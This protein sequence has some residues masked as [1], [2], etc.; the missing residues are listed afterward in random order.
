MEDKKKLTLW[1]EASHRGLSCW[2][3]PALLPGCSSALPATRNADLHPRCAEY[4][5]CPHQ[6][7]SISLHQ[8]KL[9]VASPSVPDL[10]LPLVVEMVVWVVQQHL[11]NQIPNCL[12][13]GI[14][15]PP[16]NRK[17]PWHSLGPGCTSRTAPSKPPWWPTLFIQ[18]IPHDY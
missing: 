5:L 13:Q 2:T 4:K 17:L 10:C 18:N 3:V 12:Q 15:K 9:L 14:E 6:Q 8:L 1:L 7:Q 16:R 11:S